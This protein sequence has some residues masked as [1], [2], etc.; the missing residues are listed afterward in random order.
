[1]Q[2]D[3]GTVGDYLF[4]PIILRALRETLTIAALSMVLG[5]TL[6]LVLGIMRVSANPVAGVVA[7]IYVWF[8]RATPVVLQL[9]LMYFGLRALIEDDLFRDEWTRFRA[10]VIV[11]G[12]NEAAYMAEIVR[13]GIRSVDPGQTDAAKSLGMTNLQAT[14]RVVLPQ[15]VR[16]MV[17]PT[18]N[19]FI[20]MLKNTSLLFAI[21]V[22]E[23]LNASRIQA[24]R[25]FQPMEMY[26][27]A[28]F[29]YLMV[30]TIFSFGQ[31]E[32]ERHLAMG[33]RDRPETLLSRV[34]GVMGAGR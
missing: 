14:R 13:A 29:W 34:I 10:G 12:L 33:E 8:W 16:I 6:G 11:L 17:P 26:T 7:G 18:G 2:F 21:G 27:V 15:A 30:V 25:N 5:V 3:W 4:D 9:L 22:V 28:A 31:A 24:A 1:L 23:L 32:L 19:E 20:A